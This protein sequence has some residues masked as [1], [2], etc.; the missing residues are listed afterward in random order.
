M[1]ES[2][3]STPSPAGRWEKVHHKATKDTKMTGKD[4]AATSGTLF[5][6]PWLLFEIER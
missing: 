1:D 6:A 2:E 3:R 5:V 4:L